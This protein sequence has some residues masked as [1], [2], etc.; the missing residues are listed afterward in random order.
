MNFNN[1]YTHY[2]EF[3]YL[4]SQNKGSIT[5]P[6]KM[7]DFMWHAHM[8]SHNAYQKDTKQMLGFVLDHTDDYSDQDL[9]RHTQMTD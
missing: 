6:N 3:L 2:V 8:Q 5:V 7:A 9:R 4:C 1:S